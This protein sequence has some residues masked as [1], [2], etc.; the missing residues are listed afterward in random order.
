MNWVEIV[1]LR[2]VNKPDDHVEKILE[3]FVDLANKETGKQSVK[4]YT[5][6]IIDTKFFSI[7]IFHNSNE[8]KK[9]G[10]SVGLRLVFTLKFYGL[11]NHTVWIEKR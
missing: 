6:M 8:F 11:V 10:S 9:D 1:E 7:H 4:L 2:F 3:E 5:R